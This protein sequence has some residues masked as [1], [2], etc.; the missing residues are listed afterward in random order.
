[1]ESDRSAAKSA[2][3]AFV[4]NGFGTQTFDPG[5]RSGIGETEVVG[6]KE[7][8]GFV[9]GL[10]LKQGRALFGAVLEVVDRAG[11]VITLEQNT[12]HKI[13]MTKCTSIVKDWLC[14]SGEKEGLC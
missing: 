10:G 1:M 8:K 12:W 3:V 5:E 7:N 2:M 11:L 6:Q 9:V 14:Y 13:N 4:D